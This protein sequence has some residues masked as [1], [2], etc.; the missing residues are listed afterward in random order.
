MLCELSHDLV[1]EVVGKEG[2]VKWDQ[3]VSF[4]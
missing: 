4:V 2:M 1:R 3:K